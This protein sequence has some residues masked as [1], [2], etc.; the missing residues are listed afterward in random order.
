MGKAIRDHL[1]LQ[2][3]RD[4]K[5]ADEPFAGNPAAV[6]TCRCRP[7]ALRLT[8]SNDLLTGVY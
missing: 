1:G 2:A 6:A 3:K 5:G 4:R 7:E 8:L